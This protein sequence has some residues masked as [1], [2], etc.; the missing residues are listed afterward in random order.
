MSEWMCAEGHNSL[1]NRWIW[2]S[3]ECISYQWLRN[4][5]EGIEFVVTIGF[6]AFWCAP[7]KVSSG[8]MI[9]RSRGIID[10][11]SKWWMVVLQVVQAGSEIRRDQEKVS[12]YR[13]LFRIYLQRLSLVWGW[14]ASVIPLIFLFNN[15]LSTSYLS[16]KYLWFTL[17]LKQALKL[18]PFVDWIAHEQFE[19]WFA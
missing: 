2:K 5:L 7:V 17:K 12:F 14:F 16:F 11:I 6:G 18:T 10:C 9:L 13:Y 1:L 4:G 15:F 8:K 19:K 3:C